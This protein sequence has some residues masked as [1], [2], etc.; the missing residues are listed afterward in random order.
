MSEEI[1]NR[2]QRSGLITIDLDEIVIPDSVLSVSFI[3]CIDESL[4][5]VE[6]EANM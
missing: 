5:T 1:V 2:V 4:A 6:H 3:L